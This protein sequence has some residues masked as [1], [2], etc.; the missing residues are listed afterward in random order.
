M[1]RSESEKKRTTSISPA[2]PQTLPPSSQENSQLDSNINTSTQSE[3]MV[4]F[5]KCFIGIGVIGK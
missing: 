1:I 5:L 3:N 4:Q 2:P